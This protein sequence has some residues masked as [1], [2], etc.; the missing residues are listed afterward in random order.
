MVRAL[1]FASLALNIAVLVP[2]C[3]GL[4]TNSS[5]SAAVFG[6]E[7]P[8]RAILL[9]VYLAILLCSAGLIFKPVAMLVAVLLA[10]QVI[11]KFTTP[12]TVGTFA[13]PVVISN[14]AIAAFHCVTLW[15]IW[16]NNPT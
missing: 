9:S 5:A 16:K 13:H 8:A 14:I 11:Y 12:F 1:I 2:V 6:A 3:W 15:S 10:V 7:S 4:L